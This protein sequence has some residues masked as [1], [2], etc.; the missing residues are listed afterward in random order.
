MHRKIILPVHLKL[1]EHPA[2]FF[3][4]WVPFQISLFAQHCWLQVSMPAQSQEAVL[5][6]SSYEDCDFH[7]TSTS[8][9]LSFIPA[10]SQQISQKE[11]K[12]WADLFAKL[13]IHN[14]FHF[15]KNCSENISFITENE[16]YART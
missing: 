15:T 6:E 10:P 12:V 13:S 11:N 16:I 1:T 2:I 4:L 8:S 5:V 9:F 3:S 7:T 14:L